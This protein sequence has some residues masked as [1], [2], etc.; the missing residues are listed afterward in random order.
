MQPNLTVLIDFLLMG[1]KCWQCNPRW[2]CG[3]D[4]VSLA[5]LIYRHGG[6]AW[7]GVSRAPISQS[8]RPHLGSISHP[9]PTFH[10]RPTH[11]RTSQAEGSSH[12]TKVRAWHQPAH[13]F[14]GPPPS[15][16][17]PSLGRLPVGLLL[18]IFPVFSLGLFFSVL[19]IFLKF[20]FEAL[21]SSSR[22][23]IRE[24]DA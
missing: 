17:Q 7:D 2:W 21:P 13:I 22:Y 11:P 20:T 1:C 23:L 16:K 15:K 9:G 10:L 6:G 19:W 8:V 18:W 3:A 14:K 4:A 12:Q 5:L 24:E